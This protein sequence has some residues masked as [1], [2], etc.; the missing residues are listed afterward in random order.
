[1]ALDLP[2]SAWCADFV[3]TILKANDKLL[4][5][6]QLVPNGSKK[7][8]MLLFKMVTVSGANIFVHLRNKVC[9]ACVRKKI[10]QR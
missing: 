10:S 8:E 5:R 1:M 9:D 6:H 3:E 2:I 7:T 4:N